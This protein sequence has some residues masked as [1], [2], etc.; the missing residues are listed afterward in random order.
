MIEKLK[1][2][3]IKKE[4]DYIKDYQKRYGELPTTALDNKDILNYCTS[5]IES[6]IQSAKDRIEKAFNE[7]DKIRLLDICQSNDNVFSRYFL[8]KLININLP[9]DKNQTLWLK[10]INE[11]KF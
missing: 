3:A 1:E 4:I 6:I 7:K 11:I 9:F 8:S 10:A 5:K 2:K